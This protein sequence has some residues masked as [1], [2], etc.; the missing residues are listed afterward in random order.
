MKHKITDV[1]PSAATALPLKLNA[2]DVLA[3]GSGFGSVVF[4]M[5]ALVHAAFDKYA[6]ASRTIGC[7]A[8]SAY[9]VSRS[10]FL[11]I[12]TGLLVCTVISGACSLKP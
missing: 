3:V 1:L 11:A 7:A 9:R 2:A 4:L 12:V 5:L 8:G 10:R 6:C